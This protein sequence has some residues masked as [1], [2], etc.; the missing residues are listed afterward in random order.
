MMSVRSS[1]VLQ[2]SQ[3]KCHTQRH[4]ASLLVASPPTALA[5]CP[6]PLPDSQLTNIGMVCQQSSEPRF[7]NVV[8]STPNFFQVSDKQISFGSQRQLHL[9]AES[10]KRNVE[11]ARSLGTVDRVDFGTVGQNS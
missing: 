1:E 2:C 7:Q 9:K 11:A 10:L 8:W 5:H 3:K 4:R 6:N